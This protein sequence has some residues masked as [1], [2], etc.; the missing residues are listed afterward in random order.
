MKNYLVLMYCNEGAA[1]SDVLVTQARSEKFAFTKFGKHLGHNIP[2][3]EDEWDWSYFVSHH[4][5]FPYPTRSPWITSKVPLEEEHAYMYAGE[6]WRSLY[7]AVLKDVPSYIVV[8]THYIMNYDI[9]V[10]VETTVDPVEALKSAI[11]GTMEDFVWRDLPYMRRDGISYFNIQ[12][13]EPTGNEILTPWSLWI[14]EAA[15]T[16][17]LPELDH[18]TSVKQLLQQ[19]GEVK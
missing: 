9:K 7:S 12:L 10:F 6:P 13:F 4:V 1:G 11:S 18:N 2:A 3:K 8:V 5:D 16:V 15:D 14:P 19:K 17:I